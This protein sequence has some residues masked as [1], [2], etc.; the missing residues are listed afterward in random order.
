MHFFY[1]RNG[2]KP[3]C[4]GGIVGARD[5]KGHLEEM[6]VGSKEHYSSVYNE[7]R[8]LCS[9][10]QITMKFVLSLK[11]ER[12]GVCYEIVSKWEVYLFRIV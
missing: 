1:C 7:P 9:F 3:T 10:S 5:R 4:K 6:N 8:I 2:C 11:L 12:N